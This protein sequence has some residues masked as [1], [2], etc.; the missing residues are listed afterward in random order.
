[1][2]FEFQPSILK[3]LFKAILIIIW[4]FCAVQVFSA[5]WAILAIV[6]ILIVDY[7]ADRRVWFK[8]V[9]AFAQLDQQEWNIAYQNHDEIDRVQ[10]LAIHDYGVCLAVQ[11]YDEQHQQYRYFCIIQDQVS[12]AE[13]RKLK[14]LAQFL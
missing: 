7:I 5:M 10:L 4:L 12:S 14:T 8:R 2:Y 13:W 1:M 6:A 3:I 9:K 11:S